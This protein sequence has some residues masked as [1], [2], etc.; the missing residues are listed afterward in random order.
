MTPRIVLA[1]GTFDVLHRGHLAFLTAAKAYGDR[2]IVSVTN[3][4]WVREQKGFPRPYFSIT[5]RLAMLQALRIVDAAIISD[6]ADAVEVIQTI[7]PNILAK[8]ADYSG[9]DPSGRLAREQAAVE[10][11]GGRLVIVDAW[12]RYSSTAILKAMA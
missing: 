4:Y 12:P 8:G 9:G 3:D 7:K 5:D 2:L 6:H 10:A 1:H 11:I